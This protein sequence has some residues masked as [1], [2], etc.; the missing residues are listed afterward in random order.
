ML[1]HSTRF[2]NLQYPDLLNGSDLTD[3][4]DGSEMPDASHLHND[5][6]PSDVTSEPTP[7]QTRNRL[8]SSS[9]PRVSPTRAC[10]R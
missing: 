4:L 7:S 6:D 10:Y 8:M 3:L 5:A 9:Q 1:R 2:V